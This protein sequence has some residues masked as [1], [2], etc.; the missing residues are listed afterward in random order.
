VRPL[1]IELARLTELE[2]TYL[3]VIDRGA[4]EQVILYARNASDLQIGEGLHIPWQDTV[5]KRS[6]EMGVR[7]TSDVA[8]TFPDS[9]AG[10]D[11]ELRT[12]AGVPVLSS[13]GKVWGTLCGASVH[14]RSVGEP[15]LTVMEAF[16]RLVASQLELNE[17][18]VPVARNDQRAGKQ[19]AAWW[20]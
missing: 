8:A 11:L 13:G 10:R 6:L 7:C 5:C 20:R 2:S 12:Y 17:W 16:A 15:T 18:R 4:G 9:P 19:H 3:T 1:L 14:R